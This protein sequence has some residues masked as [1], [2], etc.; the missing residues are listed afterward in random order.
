MEL[1][2]KNIKKILGIITFAIVLFSVSQNLSAVGGFLTWILKILSPV[3]VGLCIAFVLNVLMKCLETKVFSFMKKSKKK[4]VKNALRPVSLFS[5]VILTVGFIA[6]LLLIIIPELKDSVILLV[7]RVPSYVQ[8]FA[9]F[10][11]KLINRFNLDIN[12]EFLK[13]PRIDWTKVGT[14]VQGFLSYKNT[15]DLVGTTVG[16]TSYVVS[17]VTSFVL[18]FVIAIYVLAQKEKIGAFCKRISEIVLPA[19]CNKKLNEI[20]SVTSK[21]FSNFITGQ[22]TDALILATMTFIGMTI[23]RFPNPGV[24]A[25]IIGTSALIPVI[26]PIIGETVGALI[27]FMDNPWDALFFL[28]FILI[29][30]TIDNNLIYPKIVGKSVGLPGILVLISVIIGGNLGGILGVLVGVPTASAVYAIT[31]NW[32][33][34]QPHKESDAVENSDEKEIVQIEQENTENE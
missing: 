22:F 7:N 17:G 14:A 3:I 11:E 16:V 33:N 15:G 6:L 21:S 27:I 19:N 12:T 26:G 28:I 32:L 31:V 29:L 30:Q 8:G 23:F 34:K 1:S 13:N 2:K 25:V 18:G 5:T 10:F 4:Y 24:V 20:C 9:S